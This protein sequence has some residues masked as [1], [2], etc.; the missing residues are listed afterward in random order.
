MSFNALSGR[1]NYA[2][3]GSVAANDALR[4][5]IA[6]RKKS[7]DYGKLVQEAEAIRS[8][9]KIAA[10]KAEADVAEVRIRTDAAV[11]ATKILDD[12]EAAKK[13][14]QRKAGL[15]AAAG[16]RVGLGMMKY[17]EEPLERRDSSSVIDRLDE[18]IKE[19]RKKGSE[20]TNE[21][22]TKSSTIDSTSS[23]SSVLPGKVTE[24]TSVAIAPNVAPK[25][26][27]P[28]IPPS[29]V[30]PKAGPVS[31][32]STGKS[33]GS[34]AMRLMNDLTNDGYTPVQAAAIVGNAQ[35]ESANFTAYEEFVPNAYG[36]KG[37]G[38][39][40]WTNAGGSNRRSN[41]ENWSQSQNLDPKSYEASAGYML[42]ELKG[43]AGNHWTGGM[44]DA[45]FRSI[46]DLGTAVR[47]F[48]NTYLRPAEATANTQQRLKNAQDILNQW[49]KTNS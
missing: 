28:A 30:Q 45:S 27:S 44:N 20:I 4:S 34:T 16:Q 17:G 46:D 23:V 18:R 31:S 7:P 19:Y 37:A 35:H 33:G 15:L 8:R 36:T 26:I 42:H 13:K 48:Q 10:I 1:G 11:E 40:Q 43:G 5:F 39:L 22:T 9:E 32:K 47:T 38:F 12:A 2:Y 24:A 41:F 14:D 3:S 6:Q 25:I 49:F 29:A 21:S